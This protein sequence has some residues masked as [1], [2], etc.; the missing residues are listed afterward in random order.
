MVGNRSHRGA[1]LLL[2]LAAG[3]CGPE[4]G[5]LRAQLES[6]VPGER[7]QAAVALAQRGDRE[8]VPALVERLEDEDAAVRFFAILALQ[9]LTGE[10]RGYDYADPPERRRAAVL[11]WRAYL[12]E[13]AATPEQTARAGG[14]APESLVPP[15]E[16]DEHASP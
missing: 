11:R 14:A 13:S 12:R 7:V 9:R 1:L 3:G 2:M 4:T 16:S 6:R 8:S 5:R 10:R 15:R